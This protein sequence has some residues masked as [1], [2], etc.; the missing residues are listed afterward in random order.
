MKNPFRL[1]KIELKNRLC[2]QD[3]F[4]IIEKPIEQLKFGDYVCLCGNNFI[5]KS[6]E[7]E[8]TPYGNHYY[9]TDEDDRNY[10]ITGDTVDVFVDFEIKE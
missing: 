9:I 2:I 4:E 1:P 10:V 7:V 8:K 6:I 3:D 5:C